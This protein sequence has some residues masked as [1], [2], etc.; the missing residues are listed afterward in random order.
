MRKSWRVFALVIILGALIGTYFYLSK[1]PQDNV[2]ENTES[3]QQSIE[4]L[5]LDSAN[6]NKIDVTNESGKF[7]LEKNDNK[8]VI[9]GKQ[10]LKVDENMINTIVSSFTALNAEKLVQKE[11]SDLENFGLKNPKAQATAYL[12]DGSSKTIYIGNQTPEVSTYYI[13][14]K[15]SKDVYT[16]SGTTAQALN[17]SINDLRS[18]DLASIDTADLKY[19]KIINFNGEIIE[20]KAN[21]GQNE[22]EKQYGLNAFLLT[23]PYSSSH[24]VDSDKFEEL[25]TAIGGLKISSFI[26]DTAKELT[27]YGL[28]KPSLELLVK[29][30]KSELH[31]YF[32]KDI[33]EQ[34][35]AFKVAGSP[36]VYSMEKS[37]MEALNV[38]PF[39][40]VDKLVYLP[41]ID[42]VDGINIEQGSQKDVL[43][44]S[45]TTKKAEK[46]GEKDETV[47]TYK[48]NDKEVQEDSFKKFYQAIIGLKAEGINDKKLQ[49]KPDIRIVYTLNQGDKKNTV[50]SFV[51]YN[52]DFYA[53]FVDGKTEF[54]TSKLQVETAL[55]QLE[56][57]KK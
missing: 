10:N 18:K 39:D 43:S 36:E 45:R 1:K 13:I 46:E 26:N 20:I 6:I 21:E 55:K 51:N 25:K 33:D 27:K 8:W 19:L 3:T 9:S 35:V 16:V 48:V 47:T 42:T 7:S 11:T 49:E 14:L 2:S 17:Y 29:D 56:D 15:D 31:L 32:G 57:L 5:K 23:K 44:L 30:S 12:N 41:S 52:T 22:Q 28:D 37:N 40:I 50:I 53:V 54:L 38:K 24:G 4:L 34:H